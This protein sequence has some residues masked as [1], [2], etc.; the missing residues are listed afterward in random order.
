MKLSQAI[1]IKLFLGN[2]ISRYHTW[3]I[4]KTLEQ[5]KDVNK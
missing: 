4:S 5:L 1:K 2:K 3:R